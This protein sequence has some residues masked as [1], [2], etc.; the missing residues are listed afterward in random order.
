MFIHPSKP[1]VLCRAGIMEPIPDYIRN[2][3]IDNYIT[4]NVIIMSP[5]YKFYLFQGNNMI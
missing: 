1:L 5:Y 4:E 3:I 2:V